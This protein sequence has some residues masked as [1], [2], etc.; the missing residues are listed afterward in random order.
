MFPREGDAAGDVTRTR[1]A[2]D[3]RRVAV[4]HAVVDGAGLVVARIFGSDDAPVEV[5][6]VTMGGV[7]KRCRGGHVMLPGVG[8][9]RLNGPR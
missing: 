7:G 2:H 6:Q 1:A 8:G 9:R 5:S 3:D 4:D